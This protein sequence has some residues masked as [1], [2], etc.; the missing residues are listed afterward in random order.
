[1]NKLVS[2]GKILALAALVVMGSAAAP[3]AATIFTAN[4]DGI[5]SGTP[6]PGTG[7]ATLTLN[8]DE[9]EVAY[10]I[11]FSGLLGSEVAAHFHNGVAGTTGP[12]LFGLAAGSPKI[13]VWPVGPVEVGHLFDGAVYV[14]IHTDLYP[15]GEIRGDIAFQTVPDEAQS[16][17][18]IKALFR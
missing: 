6:S 8:D 7:T 14:N 17:G 9:T 1:V 4:I 3:R 12:V 13:G 18:D 11:E 10:T 5:S 2:T 15:G 16:W